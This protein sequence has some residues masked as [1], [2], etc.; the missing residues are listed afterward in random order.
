MRKKCLLILCLLALAGLLN[1]CALLP[2]EESIQLSTSVRVYT[3]KGYETQPVQRGDLIEKVKITC[4]YVPVQSVSLSFAISGEYIDRMTV[5]VGDS[6][7]RDQVLGQLQLGDLEERLAQA[8]RNVEELKLRR[9]YQEQL[10]ALNLR[11][12]EIEWKSLVPAERREASEKLEESHAKTMKAIEDDLTLEELSIQ[13][14]EKELSKRQLRAP[15][16]GTITYVR[17]YKDGARSEIGSSAVTLVDSTMSLFKAGTE[18]WDLFEKGRE[19]DI[20]VG[21]TIYPAVVVD[22]QDLGLE[23]E[24]RVAGKKANVYFALKEISFE[25]TDG[26]S[27]TFEVVLSE[28][29]D[30]LYVPQKAVSASNGQPIVYYLREDGMRAFKPVQTGVTVGGFTEIVSGLTEGEPIVVEK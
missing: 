13:T 6:V 17:N 2:E 26:A 8:Q 9:S 18:Y 28:H 24:E 20:T 12:G 25:L 23:P 3:G 7:E 19:V 22:E 15:F 16:A 4:R 11:R 27:G 10:H 30:V 5:Q 29:P 21:K 1:A 14:L